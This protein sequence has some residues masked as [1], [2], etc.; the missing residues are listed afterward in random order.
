MQQQQQKK[1]KRRKKPVKGAFGS[2]PRRTKPSTGTGAS[3]Q[4]CVEQTAT[5]LV[6]TRLALCPCLCVWLSA[7]CVVRLSAR[8]RVCALVC[9][10]YVFVC[11]CVVGLDWIGLDWIVGAFVVACLLDSRYSLCGVVVHSGRVMSVG[12]YFAFIKASNGMW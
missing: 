7:V 3:E 11:A 4:W 10:Y 12:H 6:C 9:A 5:C 2:G 8:C 1:K